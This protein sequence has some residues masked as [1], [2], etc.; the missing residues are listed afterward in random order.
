M[1]KRSQAELSGSASAPFGAPPPDTPTPLLGGLSPAQFMRRYCQKKPLLIRQA[2]PD[3]TSPLSRD[4]LFELAG[5]RTR[6]GIV[7]YDAFAW[8]WTTLTA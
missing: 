5:N 1:R 8:V 2:I 7:L 3:V 6:L 4:A